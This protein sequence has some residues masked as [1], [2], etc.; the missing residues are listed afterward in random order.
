MLSREREDMERLAQYIIR[1]P[2][3]V[4]KMRV[5]SGTDPPGET[6]LYPWLDDPFPRL[7]HRTGHGVLR[8][9]KRPAAPECASRTTCS[10]APQPS[11]GAA[12][13]KL[14]SRASFQNLRCVTR[15]TDT[16]RITVNL[17]A[18]NWLRIG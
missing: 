16:L 11:S 7:R 3:S 10:T 2:F 8:H 12:G 4:E 17:L 6:T 5:H 14:L 13:G 18:N 15:I 1:K 9:L